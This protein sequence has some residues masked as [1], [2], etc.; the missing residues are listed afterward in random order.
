[1][2]I[3]CIDNDGFEDQLTQG[4]TYRVTDIQG[5]SLQLNDDNGRLRWYGRFKFTHPGCNGYS[6]KQAA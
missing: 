4:Q 3:Q 6:S 1:M 5:Y 2:I